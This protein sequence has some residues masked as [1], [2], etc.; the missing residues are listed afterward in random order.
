MKKILSLLTVVLSIF[1]ANAIAQNNLTWVMKE[2]VNAETYK[3]TEFNCT[4]A[5]ISSPKEAADLEQNMKSNADVSSVK[6]IGKD[7]NGNYQYSV[8]MKTAQSKPYYLNWASKLGVTYIMTLDGERKS[9]KEILAAREQK[10]SDRQHQH[11]H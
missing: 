2:K 7:A 11:Q 4:I 8:L 6:N 10:S 3:K 1:S 5:G 9:I